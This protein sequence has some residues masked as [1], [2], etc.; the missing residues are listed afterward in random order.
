MDATHLHLIVNHLP[1]VGVFLSIPLLLLALWRRHDRGAL[2]AAVT[3]LAL[4]GAGAGAAFLTGEPAEERVEDL[5]GISESA[6]ETHEERAATATAV[7]GLAALSGLGLLAL[8]WRRSGPAPAA[9]FAVPIA[10][11]LVAAAAMAA[12]GASGGAIRHS[13]LGGATAG[14]GPAG[15]FAL[16]S[17]DEGKGGGQE[18]DEGED[19]D[20]EDD[21]DEEKDER[22]DREE[23]RKERK[24]SG[25]PRK[26]EFEGQSG[27]NPRGDDHDGGAPAT[28]G[29]EGDRGD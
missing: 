22:E 17:H 13:E 26:D 25:S 4:S 2:L 8:A 29:D 24:E 23:R 6:V 5:P 11:T 3:V 10:S 21:E 12:T 1:I 18:E 19:E 7:A 28:S 9:W 27:A 14:E 16:A 15:R 20:E